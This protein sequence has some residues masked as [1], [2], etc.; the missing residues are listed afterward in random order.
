[1]H[2]PTYIQFC[3]VLKKKRGIWACHVA[4]EVL[5]ARRPPRSLVQHQKP[6]G[7]P[8]TVPMGSAGAPSL[9]TKKNRIVWPPNTPEDE[10]PLL[11]APGLWRGLWQPLETLKSC[12]FGPSD[13]STGL[14][15]QHPGAFMVDWGAGVAP[16]GEVTQLF[17]AVK[18]S[19]SH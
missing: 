17:S 1:M 16:L 9:D 2:H 5:A 6:E 3:F 18:L 11:P 14:T 19:I 4:T 12:C 10:V 7:A 8:D 15:S 13:A